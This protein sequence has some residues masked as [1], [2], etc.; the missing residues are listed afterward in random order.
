MVILIKAVEVS[1]GQRPCRGLRMSR[2]ITS[3]EV[4]GGST[5][6]QLR[7]HPQSSTVCEHLLAPQCSQV[8][9]F[10]RHVDEIR[11]CNEEE[12]EALG[13]KW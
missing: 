9:D 8:V 13:F 2:G 11:G 4:W 7:L 1:L 5:P 12:F 10:E 6:A 3:A